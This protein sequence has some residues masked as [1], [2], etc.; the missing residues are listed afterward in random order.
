VE[1]T[2]VRVVDPDSSNGGFSTPPARDRYVSLQFEIMNKGAKVYQDDPLVDITVTDASG[3]TMWQD[4]LSTTTAGIQLPSDV[5][6]T[7]GAKSLGYVTF[8]VPKGDSVAQA[9][10]ALSMFGNVAQ[11]QIK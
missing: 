11:W 8:D 4:Y 9:Q 5:N 2:L 6:L 7:T 3:Q 1:V 10:Y